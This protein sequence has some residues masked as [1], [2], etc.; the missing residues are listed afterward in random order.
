MMG[1]YGEAALKAV[2]LIKSNR[3]VTP[4]N[5]WE[6]TTIEIFGKGTSS[7]A[8]GCPKS[9][10]LGLCEEGL[11]TEVRQGKYLKNINSK[12]KLYGLKA[13]ELLTQQPSLASNIKQLWELVLE[14]EHKMHNAQMDVVLSLWKNNLISSPNKK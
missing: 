2:N 10:F 1:K 9:T 13:V 11:V 3:E 12:N 8:K 5:A 4:I 6:A 14:G 7:Q